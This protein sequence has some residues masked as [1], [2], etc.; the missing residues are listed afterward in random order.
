[1]KGNQ[2]RRLKGAL[3]VLCFLF[4]VMIGTSIDEK[5]RREHERFLKIYQSQNLEISKCERE[6]R[7][8][9]E[10]IA[11]LLL[12]TLVMVESQK[13]GSSILATHLTKEEAKENVFYI[14][15]ENDL[16]FLVD[17]KEE[18]ER[19]GISIFTQNETIQPELKSDGE[20]TAIA[21]SQ[22]VSSHEEYLL[23]I[24]YA[25]KDYVKSRFLVIKSIN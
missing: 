3:V 1:M 14:E 20:H 2:E 17:Y 12:P 16:Y 10:K 18:V 15:K 4:I 7:E 22:H 8:L 9:E 21:F 13:N 5:Q 11:K 25:Y 19:I 6:K 23:T 24:T